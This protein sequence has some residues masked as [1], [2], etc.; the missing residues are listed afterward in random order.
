MSPFDEILLDPTRKRLLTRALGAEREA[1]RRPQLYWHHL[2]SAISDRFRAFADDR[3]GERPALR[4]PLLNA[5]ADAF[6]SLPQG[7]VHPLVRP[8]R[9]K[10]GQRTWPAMKRC[11]IIALHY[12]K[13]AKLGDVRD[14]H[15][16]KTVSVAFGIT[17]RLVRFWTNALRADLEVVMGNPC[18]VTDTLLP[19]AMK[20]AAASYRYWRRKFPTSSESTCWCPVLRAMRPNRRITR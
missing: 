9:K 14:P 16:V 20:N 6:E 7:Y 3:S 1:S 15:P 13:R 4:I 8:A 5:L 12:I 19:R 18:A 17:R 2:Q 11:Q 10:S